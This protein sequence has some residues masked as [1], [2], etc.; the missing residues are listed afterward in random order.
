MM[1]EIV[2]SPLNEEE[3]PEDGIYE[4][5]IQEVDEND[6]SDIA[7]LTPD[8]V[9]ETQAGQYS[10]EYLINEFKTENG[11]I[12][13]P[14]YQRKQG[15][16]SNLAKEKLIDSIFKRVPI[17]QITVFEKNGGD[18]DLVDGLQRLTALVEYQENKFMVS[19]S[20]TGRVARPWMN[21]Y[22]KDLEP[23][24]KRLFDRH[25]L[26]M[27]TIK[28]R[29]G[30]TSPEAIEQNAHFIFE[31]MNENARSLN[32]IEI[33]MAVLN[34]DFLE[35]LKALIDE[36][37]YW[38]DILRFKKSSQAYLRYSHMDYLLRAL[39]LS[40][41]LRENP[42]DPMQRYN[43]PM[44]KL[45]YDYL[46]KQKVLSAEESVIKIAEI[47]LFLERLHTLGLDTTVKRNRGGKCTVST[48]FHNMFAYYIHHYN[49][50]DNDTVKRFFSDN[51]KEK[52]LDQQ[53][54]IAGKN[55][56][57]DKAVLKEIFTWLDEQ[58]A[59]GFPLE[60]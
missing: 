9:L 35:A 54:T 51:F 22:Y 37:F 40:E 52:V 17:G 5:D 29:F 45:A 2:K 39:A 28:S 56:T 8:A 59:L 47:R 43:P 11:A 34:S 6:C 12:H 30:S 58:N 13:V 4:E 50:W 1:D 38:K 3:L 24:F 44:K 16:W 48:I 15:I 60:Q 42:T 49:D 41:L 21:K 18:I 25:T 20:N 23:E 33:Q 14:S 26:T 36:N 31:R 46:K 32:A 55:S 57:T 27:Q 53:R 19:D 7:D 10:I